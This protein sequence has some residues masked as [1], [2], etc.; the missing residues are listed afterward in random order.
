MD[1]LKNILHMVKTKSSAVSQITF[2]EDVNVPDSKPDVGRM[3]QKKGEVTVEEV[4]IAEGQARVMGKLAFF[5]LY[6]EDGGERRVH[7]LQGS[8]PINEILRLDGLQS[9]DKVRLKWEI[10]D[11]SLHLMNT[12]K[13]NVKAVVTFQ[14]S[15]DAGIEVP[16]P[17][18]VKESEGI[19]VKTRPVTVLELS[20]GRKD[21]LRIRKEILV[22]SNKP[23]VHTILWKDAEIRGLELRAEE[24][25]V[26]ARGELFVFV[27][28]EGED[29]AN[30]LQWLE[31][32]IPFTGEIECSG[33]TAEM[34]PNI[35]VAVAQTDLEVKPDSDGEERIVQT[36]VVLDM[37]ILLYCQREYRQLLDVYTPKKECVLQRT[38]ETLEQLLVRNFA[39]CRVSERFKT[40]EPE[41]KILQICHSDGSVKLDEAQ[42][43][44]D[45]ILVQG[46]VQV[47]ILYI[48]SNDE[49][50]FYSMESSIP[51]S[52]TIEAPGIS[53]ECA[54]Y[55]RSG[56]EQLSTTMADSNEIEAKAVVN[57][58][59]MVLRREQTE[60]IRAVEEREL[61]ME[62]FQ[63]MPGIVCYIVQPGDTLWDI[64]KEF[65]TT[66]EEIR[67]MN[68]LGEG[69]P[70]SGDRLLVVKKV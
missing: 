12:R 34:I 26:T 65:Y 63:S 25:K 42:I 69:E 4:Q 62:K 9:G 11:L 3:I 43:V 53:E 19:S 45:G 1:I 32:A 40:R 64:A 60:I 57:L 37:D 67:G 28:Y 50:P 66:A 41:G 56:L 33:C 48:I 44:E 22:A 29:E 38:P 49:M 13:L 58:N 36:D 61:D 21:S 39:K 31:N 5:L 51:F 14:A 27:L 15:V 55:L 6:V 30:P 8:L 46:V 70:K 35:E 16:L 23:N 2:D 24:G 68:Q 18:G 17:V 52:H 7:S 47:R 20:A 10:E 59:A 54:F